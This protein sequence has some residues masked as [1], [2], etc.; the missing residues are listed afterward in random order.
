VA[1][2]FRGLRW[3]V[4]WCR[5]GTS[6]RKGRYRLPIT[7]S[8]GTPRGHAIGWSRLITAA[9]CVVAVFALAKVPVAQV[10]VLALVLA[11][12]VAF[13]SVRFARERDE[14]KHGHSS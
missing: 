12:L 13:E 1:T 10:G 4:R 8:E 14:L 7:A 11:G 5:R 9:L 2:T 3:W 6:Y